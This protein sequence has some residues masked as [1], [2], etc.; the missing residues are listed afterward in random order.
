MQNKDSVHIND[1][2]I[3]IYDTIITKPTPSSNIFN[4][5]IRSL[6]VHQSG[7]APSL[8]ILDYLFYVDS[9]KKQFKDSLEKLEKEG[10]KI[11]IRKNAF[12]Y[13]FSETYNKDSA[14]RKIADG[15][16]LKKNWEDSIYE[17]IKRLGTFK[18]EKYQYTDMNMILVQMVIDTIN[19]KP[20]D[21]FLSEELSVPFY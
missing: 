12:D 10:K 13:Y 5:P 18:R 7:V 19:K 11:D 6:L 8:P 3:V 1:T 16:Y 20:I 17:D 2:L 15:M 4:V 9:Y 21:K 14:R